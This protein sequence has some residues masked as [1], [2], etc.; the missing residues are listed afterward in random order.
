MLVVPFNLLRESNSK[1]LGGKVTMRT[2]MKEV[3]AHSAV[4]D[5]KKKKKKMEALP[6]G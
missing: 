1:R 5:I 3:I 2:N 4:S 6:L